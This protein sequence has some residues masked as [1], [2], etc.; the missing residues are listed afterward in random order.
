MRVKSALAEVVAY[1]ILGVI[2]SPALKILRVK[3]AVAMFAIVLLPPGPL[4]MI[5]EMVFA[6]ATRVRR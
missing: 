2:K 3:I 5:G 4:T 6:G 1:A